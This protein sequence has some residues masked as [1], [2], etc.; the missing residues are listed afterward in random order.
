MELPRGHIYNK[1]LC[2]EIRLI[3]F[4]SSHHWVNG[5]MVNLTR[6]CC[7]LDE[8]RNESVTVEEL[9]YVCSQSNF[10]I[11]DSSI[12]TVGFNCK[13]LYVGIPISALESIES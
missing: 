11:E 7:N 1:T 6:A 4:Y 8:I 3:D 9:V 5:Q 12:F 2:I 10:F 13:I